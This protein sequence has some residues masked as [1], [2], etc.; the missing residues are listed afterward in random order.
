MNIPIEIY[1]VLES[2]LGREDAVVIAKSIELSLSHI[3][4]QSK[5]IP[6]SEKLK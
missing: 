6:F 1:Q 5:T 3:Q 2:K 4:E